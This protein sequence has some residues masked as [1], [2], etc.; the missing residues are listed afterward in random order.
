MIAYDGVPRG[1][2]AETASGFIH[3]D[4]GTLVAGQPHVAATW[5]PVNDH[6]L[7]KASYTF[8]ITVPRGLQAVANGELEGVRHR[9]RLDARG[10]G[11]R[12]SRWPPT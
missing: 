3:T 5:Y 8:R 6:P 1:R 7:D 11:T 10:R 4:D 12:A 2:R 9:G